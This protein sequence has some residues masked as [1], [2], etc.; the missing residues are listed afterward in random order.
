MCAPTGG[1]RPAPRTAST[2][3]FE[4]WPFQTGPGPNP[5]LVSSGISK[6]AR[7]LD[8]SL[9]GYSIQLAIYADGCFYDVDTDVRSPL[10][11]R[12]HTGW[13]ILVHLPAGQATATLWWA[14][15][16]VGR[17]GAKLVQEV[18]AWRKRDDF[19]AP[20]IFPPSD[21]V[22]VLSSGV[23]ELEHPVVESVEC[24][25]PVDEVVDDDFGAAWF[26]AMSTWAQDRIN[27]IGLLPEPRA[28]L[29]R[30][31]P[32]GVPPLRQGGVTPL[33]LSSILDLLDAVESAFSLPFPAG[34]PRLAWNR[35]LHAGEGVR[36]NQ[37]IRPVS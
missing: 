30:R 10:P 16:T 9:P 13:G 11:E 24:P 14:D 19:S 18:R 6:P 22:A 20:F 28:L 32:E 23:Y 31:W 17:I 21:E 15:L 4:S 35:G 25:Q 8:Y 12:L 34:D 37:P 26:E 5:E 29:I 3:L 7:R 36:G 27:Q 1:G 2:E 33:Q